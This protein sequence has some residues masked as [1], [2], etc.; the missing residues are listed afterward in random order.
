MAISFHA[1]N[2][3]RISLPI[4]LLVKHSRKCYRHSESE[5]S[6]LERI[7]KRLEAISKSVFKICFNSS[8]WIHQQQHLRINPIL[9]RSKIIIY[10]NSRRS[11]YR[12]LDTSAPAVF[13]YKIKLQVQIWVTKHSDYLN[14]T[15]SISSKSRAKWSV[16]L[17]TVPRIS[18]WSMWRRK[19]WCLR[20]PTIKI[21]LHFSASEDSRRMPQVCFKKIFRIGQPMGLCLVYQIEN[22]ITNRVQ[23]SILQVEAHV[24]SQARLVMTKKLRVALSI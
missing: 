11:I 14:T 7:S 8:S 9:K 12:K 5:L 2:K 15:P 6:L 1:N 18:I 20:Y 13:S 10:S 17:K 21:I 16:R 4:S 23:R 19:I 22:W 3:I 24:K